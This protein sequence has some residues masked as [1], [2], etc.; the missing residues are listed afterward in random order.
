MGQFIDL[1]NRLTN[2]AATIK[3]DDNH[4]Y[5]VNK[6][7][8]AGVLMLQIQKDDKLN[9]IEKL[10][11]IIEIGMGKEALVYINSLNLSMTQTALIVEAIMAII[12]EIELEDIEREAKKAAQKQ[13]K[14]FRK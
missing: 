14:E 3:I 12:N 13:L 2:E 8:N 10:D 4:I 5:T 7:K 9:D 11:T 1:S 6:S